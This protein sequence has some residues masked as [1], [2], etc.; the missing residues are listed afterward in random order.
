MS[1]NN[2][3]NNLMMPQLVPVILSITFHACVWHI[4]TGLCALVT[5]VLCPIFPSTY[6]Q[7]PVS[8]NVVYL[9]NVQ[10]HLHSRLCGDVSSRSEGTYLGPDLRSKIHILPIRENAPWVPIKESGENFEVYVYQ[11]K[12]D[13]PEI[14]KRGNYAAAYKIPAGSA[15]I[16]G[17]ISSVRS[18]A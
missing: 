3:G 5:V 15:I 8:I 10:Q 6:F 18:C 17:S 16:F 12:Q 4:F 13:P 2:T 1:K 9:Q 14:L 11:E 7:L